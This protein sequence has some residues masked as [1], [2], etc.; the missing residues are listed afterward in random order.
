MAEERVKLRAKVAAR[1]FKEV[2]KNLGPKH[3]KGVDHFYVVVD[4][5]KLELQFISEC[6]DIM[7]IVVLKKTLF[8]SYDYPEEQPYLCK[9]HLADFSALG[10]LFPNNKQTLNLTILSESLALE[11][12][13]N[14]GDILFK[15]SAI[16]TNDDDEERLVSPEDLRSENQCLELSVN[17]VGILDGILRFSKST[18]LRRL[19]FR[20]DTVRQRLEVTDAKEDGEM[21]ISFG[22]KEVRK[23]ALFAEMQFDPKMIDCAINLLPK[24]SELVLAFY[25]NSL[26]IDVPERQK[27]FSIRINSCNNENPHL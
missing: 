11:G 4:T 18:R 19:W 24:E 21:K 16:N 3:L 12:G 13:T 20:F 9:Y 27:L 8:A 6:K 10:V 5:E 15:V 14:P 17:R 25:P 1:V 22:V 23:V 7:L 26:L 2:F